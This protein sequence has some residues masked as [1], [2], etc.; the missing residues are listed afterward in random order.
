[1]PLNIIIPKILK[2]KDIVDEEI[3]VLQNQLDEGLI[4]EGK[5]WDKMKDVWQ[6]AMNKARDFL[7]RMWN[8]IKAIISQSWEALISFMMLEPVVRYNNNIRWPK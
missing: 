3:Q 1:M 2:M 7:I 8:K 4:D 5:F 6:N